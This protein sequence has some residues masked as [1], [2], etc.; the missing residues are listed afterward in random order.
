M[1]VVMNPTKE[2]PRGEG[3]WYIG[4]GSFFLE[5]ISFGRKYKPVI[6]F[7]RKYKPEVLIN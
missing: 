5:F 6:S 7:G 2:I 4:I 3:T 1:C